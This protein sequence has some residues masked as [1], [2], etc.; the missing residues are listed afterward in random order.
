MTVHIDTVYVLSG[1]TERIIN[2]MNILAFGS[3]GR[4]LNRKGGD[5]WL[6]TGLAK[7]YHRNLDFGHFPNGE[8]R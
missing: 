8:L 7:L 4:W 5:W 2:E 1:M 6:A 3:F